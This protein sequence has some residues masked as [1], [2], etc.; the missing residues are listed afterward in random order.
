MELVRKPAATGD[1]PNASS[2]PVSVEKLEIIISQETLEDLSSPGTLC[3]PKQFKITTKK[4]ID[5]YFK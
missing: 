5:T 1:A 2:L 3:Q 4:E